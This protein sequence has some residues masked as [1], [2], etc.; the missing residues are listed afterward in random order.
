MKEYDGG[1]PLN[2]RIKIDYSGK[3]PKVK[4]SFP[5]RSEQ[6]E[7]SMFKYIIIFWFLFNCP[8]I[9][10]LSLGNTESISNPYASTSSE[11]KEEYNFS[12]YSEFIIFIENEKVLEEVFGKINR[13]TFE[14]IFGEIQYLELLLFLQLFIIPC[15]IY[16]PFKKKWKKVYPDFQALIARKKVTSFNKKDIKID[17][18]GK[19]YCEIP[20]FS[21]ILLDYNATGEFSKYLRFFEIREHNFKY[22]NRKKSVN[23]WLWY[24]KFYFTDKPTIGKLEV[25]FK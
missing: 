8:A 14:K 23:E 4:F 12:N 22:L 10:I 1:T 19:Y 20:L 18:E 24:A 13:S 2:A 9:L 6:T 5:K 7:G 15:F 25:K 3:K 11:F 17:G 21:N 16:F